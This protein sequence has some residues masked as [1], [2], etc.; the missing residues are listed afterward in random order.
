MSNRPVTK[1]VEEVLFEYNEISS[2]VNLL[3]KKKSSMQ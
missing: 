1:N 3:F 2:V